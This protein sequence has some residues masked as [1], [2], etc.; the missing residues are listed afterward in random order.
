MPAKQALHALHITLVLRQQNKVRFSCPSAALRA[1]E[2]RKVKPVLIML[3]KQA[4]HAPE[5]RFIFAAGKCFIL[6]CA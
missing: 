6:L 5:V 3:A 1:M 4:L 2:G